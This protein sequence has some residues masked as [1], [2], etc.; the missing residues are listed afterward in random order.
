MGRLEWL[1]LMEVRKSLRFWMRGSPC[2]S[3]T[4]LG[5][6]FFSFLAGLAMGLLL[7]IIIINNQ[8][9]ITH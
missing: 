9:T 4:F 1:I 5:Y 7:C 8:S 6:F 2:S 3:V